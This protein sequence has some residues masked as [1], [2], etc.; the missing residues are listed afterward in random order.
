[1]IRYKLQ[2]SYFCYK[3]IKHMRRL[4]L[5]LFSLSLI[6]TSCSDGDI[7]TVDL[8]FEKELMLCGNITIDNYTIINDNYV[9]YDT[10]STPNESLTLLFD[11][12]S[13]TDLIFFPTETPYTKE[14]G[15]SSSTKFNYR[16]YDGDPLL[17]ICQEI[18]SSTVNITNDYP[19]S[20]GTVNF[21][22]EYVDMDGTRTVTVTIT[23]T[24]T[25]IEILSADIIELGTYTHTYPV[26]D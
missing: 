17:L 15:I 23:I 11:D 6:F 16:T 12:N 14:L 9:I 1:M 19:A 25:N 10:K 4:F 21:S 22:S 20:S 2:F 8:S 18:P 7:I 24:N 13:T 5:A 26:P 3:I